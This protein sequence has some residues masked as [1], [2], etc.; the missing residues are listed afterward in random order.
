MSWDSIIG[1][2]RIKQVLRSAVASNRLAHAYLFS[3]AAGTGK[4]AMAIELAKV[5][6][7]EQSGPDACGRCSSCL[8][9][10]SLQHPNLHLVFPLP[11]GKNEK[12]GDDPY[13][14]LSD[15]D[16][17]SIQEELRLKSENLYHKIFLPKANTI[18]V[19]SIRDIRTESSMSMFDKGRRVFVVLD[20]DYLADEG[21]NALL[22]TLEEPHDDTMLILTT[23]SP[24]SL[25]PTIISRCQHVR[26]G[27]LA[28][29]DVADALKQRE[30]LPAEKAKLVAKCANGSYSRALDLKD[31]ELGER[32]DEAVSF[33]R[34][35]LYRPPHELLNEIDTL[36]AERE[37]NEIAGALTL[38][39][40][41]LRE[42]MLY[43]QGILKKEDVVNA[44]TMEKFLRH[45]PA[46]DY[47]QSFQKLEYAISLLDKNVYIPL[48]L[49]SLALELRAVIVE[50]T[51]DRRS[52]LSV[53]A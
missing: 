14:K 22:K 21:A 53:E 3:G 49:I 47:Q 17:A 31:A 13:V 36:V 7:C 9:M 1:Q 24:D 30:S 11:V 32:Y 43:G 37:R 25:L 15:D 4:S 33:L 35:A 40:S 39:E 29:G 42:T 44:E 27:P 8:K 5:I 41:W 46:I 38:L 26:F 10:Q 20:A 28:D 19:N 45:H 52:S 34:S 18:K 6:N 48:V 23:S 51:R 12:Y 50:Q 16:I 2:S